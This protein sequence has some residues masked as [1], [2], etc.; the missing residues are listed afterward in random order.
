MGCRFGR[1]GRHYFWVSSILGF[2]PIASRRDG[3]LWKIGH[4]SVFTCAQIGNND[5]LGA[6][7]AIARST[8]REFVERLK[9]AK[10]H[11]P[12]EAALDAWFHGA[13]AANWKNPAELKAA[14]SNASIAGNDRVVFN[15]EDNSFRLV[16]AA[17]YLR[18]AVFIK[19]VGSHAD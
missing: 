2:L 10:K 11:A 19:W 5:T 8:L 13:E 12:V 18:Q 1:L 9:G 4:G 14:H 3:R 7:R 16:A 17:D 15:I 6:V